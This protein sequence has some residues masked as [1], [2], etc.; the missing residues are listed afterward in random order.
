M[1]DLKL[2]TINFRKQTKK[3]EEIFNP[4]EFETGNSSFCYPGTMNFSEF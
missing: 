4:P 2:K 3:E 1:K